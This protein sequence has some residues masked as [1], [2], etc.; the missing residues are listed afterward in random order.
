M[1]RPRTGRHRSHPAVGG[2]AGPRA[3]TDGRDTGAPPRP[4][5]TGAGTVGPACLTP[6]PAD[7]SITRQRHIGPPG[8]GKL[9]MACDRQHAPACILAAGRPDRRCHID[10]GSSTGSGRACRP[11]TGAGPAR[12]SGTR[13]Q[14]DAGRRLATARARDGLAG[15]SSGSRPAAAPHARPPATRWPGTGARGRAAAMDIDAAA[16]AVS[17][18]G[19]CDRLAGAAPRSAPRRRPD[20]AVSAIRAHRHTSGCAA[21]A[22]PRPGATGHAGNRTRAAARGTG[23]AGRGNARNRLAPGVP[24]AANPG[25]GNPGAGHVRSAVARGCTAPAIRR[26]PAAGA[27]PRAEPVHGGRRTRGARRRSPACPGAACP[28]A[29]CRGCQRRCSTC[30]RSACR[31]ARLRPDGRRLGRAPTDGAAA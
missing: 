9:A 18:R 28:G 24:R 3:R 13:S 20:I 1:G 16:A 6:A 5:H 2:T 17:P 25:L 26:P 4:G 10:A 27:A 21:I 22:R 29:T 15:R 14:P 7:R 11:R 12:C 31:D 30:R 19:Q 8:A 23:Q